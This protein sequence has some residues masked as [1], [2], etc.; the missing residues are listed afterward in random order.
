MQEENVTSTMAPVIPDEYLAHTFGIDYTHK[1]LFL[2]AEYTTEDST[3]IP[4]T[5]TKVEGRYRWLIEPA[6]TASIGLSNQWLDFGEPDDRQ[7]RLF[8]ASAEVFSRLTDHYSLSSSVNYRDEEDS[9]FGATR[10][11]HIDN[12]LEY[13]YRQFSATVGAEL[14]FLE[15]RD[16]RIDS[17]FLY[18][19]AMRRF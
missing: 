7:V 17:V 13:Q 1:G 19:R 2:L 18:L 3:V 10:G 8:E 9:R 15:R 12:K 5:G 14:N 6:T 16:D 4:M 11:F